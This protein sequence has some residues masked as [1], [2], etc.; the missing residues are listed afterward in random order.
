M[1]MMPSSEVSPST[2]RVGGIVDL[3]RV[4]DHQPVA[5]DVG[6]RRQAVELL[7]AFGDEGIDVHPA[8]LGHDQIGIGR[9]LELDCDVGFQPRDVGLLHGAAQVDGDLAIG[10]VEIDQPRQYPEIARS[11]RDGD[12]NGSGRIARLRGAAE[13]IEGVA[14]HLHDVADHGGAFFAQCQ[15]ALIAQ[16][17]LAADMLFEAVDPAHQR[18]AGE[19]ERVGGVAETLVARAGEERLQVVPGRVLNL[20]G[21]VLHRRSTPVQ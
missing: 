2:R 11:L 15:S 4:L 13:Q 20:V 19:P 17:Q 5:P 7:V 16:E 1:P 10:P 3:R 14:F 6:Q 9:R 8:E 18:G 12:A 21:A